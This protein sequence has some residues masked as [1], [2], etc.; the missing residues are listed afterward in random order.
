MDSR[1]L[2]QSSHGSLPRPLYDEVRPSLHEPLLTLD[3]LLVV[4]RY[5]PSLDSLDE[6]GVELCESRGAAEEL[7]R[8]EDSSEEENGDEV[9]EDEPN[10]QRKYMII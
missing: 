10:L 7:E 9:V 3:E 1:S 8:G 5:V 2:H 4:E 6:G